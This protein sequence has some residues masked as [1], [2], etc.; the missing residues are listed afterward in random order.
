MRILIVAATEA[1]IA[2]IRQSVFEANRFTNLD[3]DFLITGVGMPL[4]VLHMCSH[5]SQQ[6]PYSLL[7]NLGIAGAYSIDKLPIGKVCEVVT[8]RMGDL[9]A[10]LPDGQL[11][12]WVE[13]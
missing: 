7:L 12:D 8:D 10:E 9:G 3:L 13:M 6:P 2:P 5:L 1:E 11:M 4:T